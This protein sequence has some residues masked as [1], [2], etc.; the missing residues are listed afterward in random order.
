M[1]T[2]AVFLNGLRYRHCALDY[3]GEGIPSWKHAPFQ[4][5][6]HLTIEHLGL[7]IKMLESFSSRTSPLIIG[8]AYSFP[9]QSESSFLRLYPALKIERWRERCNFPISQSQMVARKVLEQTLQPPLSPI[10]LYLQDNLSFH[11]KI[12]EL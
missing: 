6:S 9:L 2:T 5:L 7:Y 12:T 11:R 10:I 3:F 4:I 8:N 1:K